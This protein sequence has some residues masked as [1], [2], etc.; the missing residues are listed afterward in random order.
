MVSRGT[1][2]GCWSFAEI[3]V[4]ISDFDVDGMINPSLKDLIMVVRVKSVCAKAVKKGILGACRLPP[5][6]G[7]RHRAS[8]KVIF[9]LAFCVNEIWKTLT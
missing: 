9:S 1:G 8:G 7:L 3:S 4:T 5:A 6:K 2:N